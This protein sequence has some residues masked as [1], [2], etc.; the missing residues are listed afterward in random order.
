MSL[1][2]VLQKIHRSLLDEEAPVVYQRLM[3]NYDDIV[4]AK[5]DKHEIETIV[6]ADCNALEGPGVEENSILWNDIREIQADLV[7]EAGEILVS[8]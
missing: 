8:V 3:Q 7:R 4:S 2:A 5:Y 6:Y 1:S